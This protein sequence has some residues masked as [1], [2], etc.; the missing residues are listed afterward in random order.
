MMAIKVGYWLKEF[1]KSNGLKLGVLSE[2]LP[3]SCSKYIIM[4]GQ[5][6]GHAEPN[7]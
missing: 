7:G 4:K 2:L 1:S 3:Y 6:V 5:R